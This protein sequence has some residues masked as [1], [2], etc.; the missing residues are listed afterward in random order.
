MS[1]RWSGIWILWLALLASPGA[2]HVTATGLAVLSV[3]GNTVSYRL[4]L[5]L[6]ELPSEA[7]QLLTRAANGGAWAAI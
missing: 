7:A 4:T 1:L 3:D 5:V 2:A 6:A